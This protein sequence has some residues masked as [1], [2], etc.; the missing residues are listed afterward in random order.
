M[1]VL[2][3]IYLSFLW[4]LIF[5]PFSPASVQFIELGPGR[6]TLVDDVCRVFAQ[7][8]DM[9]SDVKVALVELSQHQRQMQKRKLETGNH[10]LHDGEELGWF[11]LDS[12]VVTSSL[13]ISPLP[14][15]KGRN[16]FYQNQ[17]YINSLL[18]AALITDGVSSTTRHGFSVSWFDHINSV[19][20][21]PFWCVR[22][23]SC[24]SFD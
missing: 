8:P 1:I 9:T 15:F 10:V 14:L 20:A 2:G 7:I 12:V 6:G 18:F 24:P 22:V 19:P 4:F 21:S 3:S 13:M 16:N 11:S 5:I 17:F 23:K